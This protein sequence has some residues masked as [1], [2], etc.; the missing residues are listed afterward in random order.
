MPLLPRTIVPFYSLHISLSYSRS[1]VESYRNP[2]TS[3]TET[4]NVEPSSAFC[5]GLQDKSK[6]PTPN[7]STRRFRRSDKRRR[8]RALKLPDII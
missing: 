3:C 5:T 2:S 8:D 7:R 4:Y 1:T 6:N